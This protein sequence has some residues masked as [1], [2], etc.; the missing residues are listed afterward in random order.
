MPRCCILVDT[1]ALTGGDRGSGKSNFFAEYLI[2]RCILAKTNAVCVRE[3]QKSLAQS[4]KKLLELKIEALGVGHLFEV[5][6]S[7]I[8]AKNGGIIL[9]QGLQNHNIKY[10]WNYI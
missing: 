9:F 4:V 7:V 6:E 2:E 5:Q 1:R 10:I 8:K 3:I